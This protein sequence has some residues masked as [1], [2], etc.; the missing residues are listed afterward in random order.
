MILGADRW[1]K[2]LRILR[3]RTKEVVGEELLK[4]GEE[5]LSQI[6]EVSIDLGSGYKSVVEELIP[7]AEVVADRFHVMK[8]INE[9]LDLM[10][11][12]ERREIDKIKE[13]EEKEQKNRAISNSKYV[14]L[15]NRKDFKN[16]EKEKLK[17]FT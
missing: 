6:E 11:K 12:K 8:K 2:L 7:N 15:K 9:E 14:L 3:K 13:K 16:S 17:D 4:W 5:V 10:R 1:V